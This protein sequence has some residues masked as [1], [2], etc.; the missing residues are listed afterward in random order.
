MIRA[1]ILLAA[2]LAVR[3]S[4]QPDLGPFVGRELAPGLH[5]LTTPPDYLGR[6]IGNVSII[7]QSDGLVLVDSGGTI[8]DGRRVVAYIR[9]FT[10]KPV[11]AIL[12]THWHG[13]HP[14]G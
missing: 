3:A 5:L 14:L 6:V 7:E 12:I 11:K 8:A 1:L 9:S 13:D 2:L 4:A 10:R